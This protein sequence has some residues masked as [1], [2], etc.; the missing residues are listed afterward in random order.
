MRGLS[1]AMPL[2]DSHCHID[3][4]PLMPRIDEVLANARNND[5]SHLLCVSVNLE[6]FPRIASLAEQHDHIFASV[7]VHPNE[8]DGRDPGVEE[9]VALSQH[10]RV[11]AI[12]ETGLD[13]FRSQRDRFRRHIQAAR[14]CGKPLII[15]S[16]D[17]PQ[18]TIRFMREEDAGQAGGVMHCFAEDWNMAQQA[19]ELG[20]YISFSGIVTFKNAKPVQDV[21]L[22][23]A[24]PSCAEY[25][26]RKSR[27]Q[28]VKTFSHCSLTPPLSEPPALEYPQELATLLDQ[29]EKEL[30]LLALWE[31]NPPPPNAFESP[32]PFCFDTMSLPQWL[33]W[34]FIPRMRQT[35]ALNVPLPAACQIAPVV[36][37]YFDD[38]CANRGQLVVLLEIFDAL[39]PDPV[40]S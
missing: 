24:W 14:Q 30:K 35:L 8:Q 25:H 31:K 5:V 9:L 36:E 1:A 10:P 38:V 40:T 18:D 27:E 11:V 21:A 15:H 2:V 39:M 3:F 26:M 34:V 23:N 22:P 7:G 28:P 37:L 19:L 17:A 32:N 33:Q 29:I 13:Y 12:G 20:F 4:D 16:R 6:D